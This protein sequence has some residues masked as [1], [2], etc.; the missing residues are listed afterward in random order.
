MHGFHR[1]GSAL[2]SVDMQC[3]AGSR[4]QSTAKWHGKSQMT[5]KICGFKI[6]KTL[7]NLIFLINTFAA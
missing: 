3:G 4:R 1:R 2:I 7:R 5:V 6:L